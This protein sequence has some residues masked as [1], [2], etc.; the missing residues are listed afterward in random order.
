[1]IPRMIAAT[2]GR[3]NLRILVI[4]GAGLGFLWM[5]DNCGAC[6][7]LKVIVAAVVIELGYASPRCANKPTTSPEGP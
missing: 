2:L 5:L 7:T 1:M 6:W 4:P 3:F